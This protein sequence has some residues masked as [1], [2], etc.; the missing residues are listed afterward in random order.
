MNPR[1]A[2]SGIAG[3]D[4]ILRGGFQPRQLYLIEGGTGVGKTTLALQFLM[5]G[6]RAGE[7]ALY[8]GFS[9]TPRDINRIA[10]T[11]GWALG[12]IRLE[13]VGA[14]DD[15]GE[16]PQYTLFPS[17]EVEL[18]ALMAEIAGLVEA[19]KPQRVV[20]DPVSALCWFAS[21][22]AEYRRYMESLRRVLDR[23]DC[24]SLLIDDMDA[25]GRQFHSRGLA[26]G[27]LLLATH[28]QAYGPHRRR[29]RLEKLRGV[30]VATGW[31]DYTIAAGGLVV[32]PRIDV[33][34]EAGSIP[35]APPLLTGVA[36]FDA[37][38]GGGIPTGSGVL[39]AGPAGTGKSTIAMS[40]ALAAAA[41]R[42]RVVYLTFDEAPATIHARCEAL[43]LEAAE[44][45][46]AG[47][48]E[49]RKIDTALVSPGEIFHT[50]RTAA[51]APGTR[52]AMVVLDSISG[53]LHAT[54]SER[55]LDL[56]LRQLLTYLS[57]RG[58]I[59]IMIV[60]QRGIV[61]DVDAA[62][63]LSYL[64]DITV[65]TRFFEADG[66]LH[67]A[68]SIVKHRSCAHEQT[69]RELT[70]SDEGVQLSEPLSGFRGLLTGTAGG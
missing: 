9:E 29:L 13:L 62:V 4:E 65:L 31:H 42:E 20:I 32:H 30:P 21:D 63:D 70:F 54:A 24:T 47:L 66:S 7:R 1:V 28:E 36:G 67:R 5:Q 26:D 15:A 2:S 23:H 46:A 18:H 50:I 6:D 34:P 39:I 8:I 56:Q 12:R 19:H 33:A 17:S 68:I 64:C 60:T 52:L 55:H 3:L 22:G 59:G 38:L 37:L 35:P 10:A 14:G 48:L 45:L 53:F 11:H 57:E 40:W 69:I 51:E 43:G 44:P 27:V 25:A 16:R 58:V 49:L 61:G 41:R